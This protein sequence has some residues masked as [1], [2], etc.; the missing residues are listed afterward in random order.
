M[1]KKLINTCGW[2]NKKNTLFVEL[3][4]TSTWCDPLWQ[5]LRPAIDV[6]F[7]QWWGE[8]CTIGTPLLQKHIAKISASWSRTSASDTSLS[9]TC[10][11]RPPVK[12]DHLQKRPVLVRKEGTFSLR[13]LP[14]ISN[15]RS[16]VQTT[17][18]HRDLGWSFPAGLTVVDLPRNYG[19]EWSMFI[20]SSTGHA[21]EGIRS[22]RDKDAQYL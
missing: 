7:Y 6:S 9:T 21:F 3:Q 8:I 16:L 11:R 10:R 13:K 4:K 12:G 2:Y 22:L 17:I 1:G 15:R 19:N 20:S 18:F 5:Q 14:V